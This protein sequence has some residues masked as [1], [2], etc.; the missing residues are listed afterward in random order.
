MELTKTLKLTTISAIALLFLTQTGMAQDGKS[1]GQLQRENAELRAKVDSLMIELESLKS[2][3]ANE[4]R[5]TSEMIEIF[6][7]SEDKA[8]VA[9]IEYTQETTD[10]LR[11]THL[12]ALYGN[13]SRRHRPRQW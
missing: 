6:E 4:S 12:Y 5:I 11:E 9:D 8:N 1:K 13:T 3:M 10:S 7:E 2:E